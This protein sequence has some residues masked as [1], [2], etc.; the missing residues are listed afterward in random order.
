M[1]WENTSVRTLLP[2]VHQ[3]SR[4]SSLGLEPP[5]NTWIQSVRYQKGVHP[6][7]IDKLL[8]TSAQ[9]CFR[10]YR[11]DWQTSPLT[12]LQAKKSIQ[13]SWRTLAPLWLVVFFFFLE[14]ACLMA[15]YIQNFILSA[16]WWLVSLTES[17][18]F[19]FQT[20]SFSPLEFVLLPMEIRK[21]EE[22][23]IWTTV[24]H[25]RTWLASYP[26]QYRWG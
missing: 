26:P 18:I 2:H 7:I 16:L 3:S 5:C 22:W 14:I 4:R 24:V 8:L 9:I 23:K 6:E 13:S 25:K 12:W 20:S 21:C 10:S 15:C 19:K 11:M 1:I 17:V